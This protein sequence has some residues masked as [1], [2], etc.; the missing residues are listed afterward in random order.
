MVKALTELREHLEEVKNPI[1]FFVVMCS[2]FCL[3]AALT[4]VGVYFYTRH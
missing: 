4:L 3:I 1:L 2:I